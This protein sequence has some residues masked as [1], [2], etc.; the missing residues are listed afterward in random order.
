MLNNEDQDPFLASLEAKAEELE[1]EAAELESGGGEPEVEEP[2]VEE[3]EVEEEPDTDIS[4]ID[5][6]QLEGS[7][8]EEEEPEEEEDEPEVEEEEPERKGPVDPDAIYKQV[9]ESMKGKKAGDLRSEIGAQKAKAMALEV[10]LSEKQQEIESFIK[11]QE[12]AE[13]KR[14]EQQTNSPVIDINEY[15]AY[16][17]IKEEFAAKLKSTQ[18]RLSGDKNRQYLKDNADVLLG[19]MRQMDQM[20]GDARDEAEEE[21]K[22]FLENKFGE[23]GA[24]RVWNFME[25]AFEL[26]QKASEVREEFDDNARE[27]SAKFHAESYEN[28][29]KSL[30]TVAEKY[31]NPEESHKEANPYSLRSYLSNLSAGKEKGKIEKIMNNDSAFVA[32]LTGGE[33]PFNPDDSQWA[34]MSP[35]QAKKA[36][37]QQKEK[38][39]AMQAKLVPELLHQALMAERLF[40]ILNKKVAES[41]VKKQKTPLPTKGKTGKRTS[42]PKSLEADLEDARAEA[43]KALASLG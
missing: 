38:T 4:S 12:E 18:R 36:Y 7:L 1:S 33:P 42:K 27:T 29:R 40:P 41:V 26:D 31:F 9:M 13:A 32:K 3:P 14:I 35:E 21:M 17:E 10:Q 39:A 19:K 6:L 22:S 8:E 30:K 25:D 16:Q 15:P 11:Q 5:D 2:E 37:A 43:R 23:K 34:G 24:D 28:H 20:E